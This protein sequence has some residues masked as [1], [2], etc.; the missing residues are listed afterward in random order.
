MAAN[1]SRISVGLRSDLAEAVLEHAR[2]NGLASPAAAAGHLIEVGL[3]VVERFDP[4]ARAGRPVL[5]VGEAPTAE[6]AAVQDL[7]LHPSR[8]ASGRRLRELSGLSVPAFLAAFER[9]NVLERSLEPEEP[10]PAAEARRRGLAALR[11][12]GG[13]VVVMLGD[14]AATA[15]LGRRTGGAPRLVWGR[16][17]SLDGGTWRGVVLPHPSGRSRWWN[18]PA[19]RERAAA[20]LRE[21]VAGR[22][23]RSTLAASAAAR[24]PVAP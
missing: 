16:Y 10:W 2:R 8:T 13:R 12:L 17:P 11:F 7:W 19:R 24:S 15:L 23:E 6:V 1:S 3:G 14:R 18:D 4:I 22:L 21:A 20:V 9:T 5:L